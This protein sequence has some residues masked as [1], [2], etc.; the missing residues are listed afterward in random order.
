MAFFAFSEKK[1]AKA[2]IAELTAQIEECEY[3]LS[4]CQ[5]EKSAEQ[6]RLARWEEAKREQLLSGM[7]DEYPLPP[8]PERVPVVL[9]DGTTMT[10]AQLENECMMDLILEGMEP[11]ILYERTDLMEI[12][13]GFKKVSV[14]RIA[15]ISNSMVERGYLQRIMEG[16]VVYFSLR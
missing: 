6:E 16:G 5:Q 1:N 2:R 4:V 10:V 12:V 11:D 15:A 13:S 7:K 9:D 14:Q 3:Q 8:E